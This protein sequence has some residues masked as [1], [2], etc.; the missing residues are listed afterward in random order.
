MDRHAHIGEGELGDEG[1]RGVLR[2][3]RLADV[4]RVLE[5]PKDDDATASD[6]RNLE[7]LRRLSRG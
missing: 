4:P 7:A 5:T 2:D 6:R 3:P 1:F